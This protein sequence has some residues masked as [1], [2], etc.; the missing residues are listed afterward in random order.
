MDQQPPSH[1][2]KY[3][4]LGGVASIAVSLSHLALMGTI[5]VVW[6]IC[7]VINALDLR[8]RHSDYRRCGEPITSS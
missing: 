6:A 2:K 5:I 7:M 8:G 3:D 4:M 1:L